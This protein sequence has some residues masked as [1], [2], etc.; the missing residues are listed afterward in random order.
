MDARSRWVASAGMALT[1]TATSTEHVL[2]PVPA[3]VP[4]A[5]RLRRTALAA[6]VTNVVIVVTGGLVRLTQSGLGCPDWPTCSGSRIIPE[7]AG[8]VAGW[9]Q[10]IEFGN[11]LLTGMVLGVA[12]A[13]VLAARRDA[14]GGPR[15]RPLAWW[16]LAGVLTQAVLGGITVLTGLHP[17]WVAAHYLVSAALIAVAAVAHDRVRAQ[18]VGDEVA[19]PDALRRLASLVVPVAAGVLVMGTLVTG[20]GPHAGDPGTVRLAL[21]VRSVAFLHA[22][23]V[24]LLVGLSVATL[25]VAQALGHARVRRAAAVLVAVELAQGTLGYVQ[26]AAGVPEVLVGLHL[27]GSTLVWLAAW[28]LLLQASRSAHDPLLV[29]T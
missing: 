21:D 13:L 4:S 9:H 16:L 22:D 8:D 15:V 18:R 28:R 26:Y 11:R 12:I 17:L 7:L 19:V 6:I 23:L 3:E 10:F 20:A 24:W 5:R 29:V 1:P 27:L 14:D 2:S 25:V